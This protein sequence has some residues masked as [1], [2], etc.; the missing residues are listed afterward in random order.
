DLN[1]FKDR[2]DIE[3]S[4]IIYL[5]INYRQSKNLVEFV[6]RFCENSNDYIK[7]LRPSIDKDIYRLTQPI[8]KKGKDPESPLRGRRG[9]L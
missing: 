9:Y 1:I 5:D 8:H 4:Q 7:S 6:N 2:E 3:A